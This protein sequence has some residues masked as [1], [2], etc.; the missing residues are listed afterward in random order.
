MKDERA[1]LIERL[2]DMAAV[3]RNQDVLDVYDANDIEQADALLAADAQAGGEWRDGVNVARLRAALTRVG[4][5]TEPS[6]EGMSADL[7]NWIN[8]LTRAVTHP[9]PQAVPLTEEQIKELV[10]WG[11]SG[12]DPHHLTEFARAIEAAHGIKE[13]E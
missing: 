13:K 11:C 7:E 6:E 5:A 12:V 3:L 9:Q 1:E 4:V 8:T 10:T 2:R